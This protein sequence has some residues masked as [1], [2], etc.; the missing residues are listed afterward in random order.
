MPKLS[1]PSSGPTSNPRLCRILSPFGPW[2]HFLSLGPSGRSS[3]M[4][5]RMI[6][7][8]PSGSSGAGMPAWATP[9]T[10]PVIL[11]STTFRGVYRVHLLV[12]CP[13]MLGRDCRSGC[14]ID[15][16]SRVGSISVSFACWRGQ[17]VPQRFWRWPSSQSRGHSLEGLRTSRYAGLL[18]LEGAFV[19]FDLALQVCTFF[20]FPC[21]YYPVRGRH[22]A[23][24]IASNQ[25]ITSQIW[26]CGISSPIL[27]PI[28]TF[29]FFLL[30]IFTN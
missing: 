25:K 19:T 30:L 1:P 2:L 10:V 28:R 13:V 24:V 5:L 27:L 15:P 4:S 22:P 12:C 3:F 6:G 29:L 16:L 21:L 17:G 9:M 7:S 20:Y 26:I 14:R 8:W 18:L 11:R 23:P